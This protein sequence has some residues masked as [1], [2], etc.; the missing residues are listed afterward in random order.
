MGK[1]FGFVAVMIAVAIGLYVY[2][3]DVQTVTPGRSPSRTID[4]TA[5]RNDLIAIANAER[6]YFAT[7]GKYASLDELRSNGDIQVPSR[8]SY[9]YSAETSDSRF[10]I[11][12]TY[13]GADPNAPKRI[14]LD[15]TMTVKTD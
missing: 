9:T 12:A 4:V 13:T 7:N 15:E 3:K 1:T 14:S 2:T 6:R 5:V 11:I 10:T 8:A